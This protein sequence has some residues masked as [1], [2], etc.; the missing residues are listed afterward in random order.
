M[1]IMHS[2]VETRLFLTVTDNA[3]ELPSQPFDRGRTGPDEFTYCSVN[4]E[5]KVK[6]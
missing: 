1:G 4:D 6:E 2:T 5:Q 3:H